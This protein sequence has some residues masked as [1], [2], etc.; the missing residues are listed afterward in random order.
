[1]PHDG[2]VQDYK[3]FEREIQPSSRRRGDDK[4]SPPPAAPPGDQEEVY[5]EKV[6]AASGGVIA[7]NARFPVGVLEPCDFR[8]RRGG[9]QMPGRPLQPG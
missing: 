4:T 7:K 8:P 6:T 3:K 1:M 5:K 2:E 9:L